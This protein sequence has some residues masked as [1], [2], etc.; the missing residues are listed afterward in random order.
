MSLVGVHLHGNIKGEGFRKSVYK[1][2]WSS[3]F[4][5]VETWRGKVSAKKSALKEVWSLIRDSMV[6]FFD[7]LNR[8]VLGIIMH[9]SSSWYHLQ[10]IGGVYWVFCWR[11]SGVRIGW[12]VSG[13][14]F[15]LVAVCQVTERELKPNGKNIPVT[16]RNKKEYLDRMVKWRLER[17]V[18]EQTDSLIKGFHEVNIVA[19]IRINNNSS[20]VCCGWSGLLLVSPLVNA[21]SFSRF[22]HGHKELN[23]TTKNWT[24]PM[25]VV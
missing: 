8:I 12:R 15:W 2:G 11:A 19:T 10:N 21:P 1:K 23:R 6:I 13:D 24:G 22:S 17:G 4:I 7:L 5:C 3:G 18:T 16:E 9:W 20:L 25:S 14:I